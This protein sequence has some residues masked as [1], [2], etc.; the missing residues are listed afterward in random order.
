MNSL[1]FVFD[2]DGT[3]TKKE[4]LPHL[5]EKINASEKMERWTHQAMAGTVPFEESF[6]ERVECLKSIALDEAQKWVA[7]VPLHMKILRF[8]E[9]NKRDCCI[10]TAN[11]DV[12]IVGLLKKIGM[13]AQTFSSIAHA[14]GNTLKGVQC[15]VDKGAV[16]RQLKTFS[17][18]I[19]DGANDIAML[20]NASVGIAFGALRPLPLKLREAATFRVYEEDALCDLLRYLKK[21]GA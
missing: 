21:R 1:K 8:I 10:V 18:A 3:L 19:G 12:W 17:I 2:L 20:Q 13:E 7:Q 11:L 6:K 4:I 9:N 14:E 5:A 16:V 15:I